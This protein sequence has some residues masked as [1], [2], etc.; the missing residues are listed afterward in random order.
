MYTPSRPL[1]A[2]PEV[3][4]VIRRQEYIPEEE[5]AGEETTAH[6]R[7]WVG[8]RFSACVR[9]SLSPLRVRE[10]RRRARVLN[11][12]HEVHF[13]C[14]TRVDVRRRIRQSYDSGE[15]L[16]R[17]RVRTCSEISSI[18]ERFTTGSL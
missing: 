5:T 9:T 15:S 10:N 18:A 1:E 17:N 13:V 8:Q 3:T 11:A 12:Y 7:L 6:A 4:T 16:M 14:F 2:W